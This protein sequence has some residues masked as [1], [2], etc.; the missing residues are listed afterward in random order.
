MYLVSDKSNK[1][2][3][4]E[5]IGIFSLNKLFIFAWYCKNYFRKHIFKI[6]CGQ[7]LL[8]TKITINLRGIYTAPCVMI[9]RREIDI[10]RGIG[11]VVLKVEPVLGPGIC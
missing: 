3:N 11:R 4:F 10:T 1:I 9:L 5:S 2:V 6:F 8:L 7:Y